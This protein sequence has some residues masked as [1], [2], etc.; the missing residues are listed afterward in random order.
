LETGSR[1]VLGCP[2]I[3]A[4]LLKILCKSAASGRREHPIVE[5]GIMEQ[6]GIARK[7]KAIIEH[8]WP[9]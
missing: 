4:K 1:E 2:N 6:S 8:K 3:K 9:P 5:S 7:R